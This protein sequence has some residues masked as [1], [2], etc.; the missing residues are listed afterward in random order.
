[1]NDTISN[2]TVKE[3]IK[4]IV[5]II[6]SVKTLISLS[7]LALIL[8]FLLVS[9]AI[10]QSESKSDFLIL[11]LIAL[12]F[13]LI[14]FILFLATRIS[15]KD[16]VAVRQQKDVGLTGR[17]ESTDDDYDYPSTL[18]V[19]EHSPVAEDGSYILNALRVST[20]RFLKEG[21]IDVT[22][23]RRSTK[24]IAHS[25]SISNPTTSQI[26]GDNSSKGGTKTPYYNKKIGEQEII[27]LKST[28]NLRIGEEK[29]PPDM[30]DTIRLVL[31]EN[32]FKTNYHHG[33]GT[34]ITA[35]TALIRLLIYFP[36]N[37]F[38]SK[39]QSVLIDEKGKLYP[40][41][42]RIEQDLD[43]RLWVAECDNLEK[44]VGAFVCWVWPH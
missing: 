44:G 26:Y 19:F 1:M 6:R 39:V 17:L 27:V 20:V 24:N 11:T 22:I 42:M 21:D 2:K 35:T 14:L 34:R 41:I 36:K 12:S 37:Y 31:Y 16:N 5:D 33:V 25:D 13:F 32:I 43:E 3:G 7:A 18:I 4:G 40:D 29:E 38:P 10:Y 9:V 8:I 30:E 23:P 15:S 28:R